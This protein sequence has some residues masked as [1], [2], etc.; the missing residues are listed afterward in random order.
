[1]TYNGVGAVARIITLLEMGLFLAIYIKGID[2]RHPVSRMLL[3]YT[4]SVAGITILGLARLIT[5]AD[6]NHGWFALVNLI[7]FIS[8]PFVIFW[9]LILLI[10]VR[11]D[12]KPKA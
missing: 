9:Q 11:R 3:A 1:M 10:K 7:M 8:L 6:A 12:D 5:H 2:W 4:L